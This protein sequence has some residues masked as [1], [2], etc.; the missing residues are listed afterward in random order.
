MARVLG[1]VRVAATQLLHVRFAAQHR[2]NDHLMQ[3]NLLGLQAVEEATAYILKQYGGTRHEIRYAAAHTTVDVVE[4]IAAHVHQFRLAVLGIGTV[5]NR[6]HAV[7]R[8][9]HE[10]HIVLIGERVAEVRHA[11]YA[12]L[13][14][15]AV[16]SE[17]ARRAAKRFGSCSRHA[18]HLLSRDGSRLCSQ[19]CSERVG[20]SQAVGNDCA[21]G[22]TY[23]LFCWRKRQFGMGAAQHGE[24]N[25][26]HA[27]RLRISF[28]RNFHHNGC[29]FRQN[30]GQY[31]TCALVFIVVC[32]VLSCIFIN[33]ASKI[34]D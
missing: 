28:R 15:S 33:F 14:G 13:H 17:E 7:A 6:L 24:Q 34:V 23:R 20:G 22:L 16:G 1:G 27:E 25:N 11:V 29:K 31:K 3:R 26:S 21:V 4:R 12:V 2:R 9:S 32:F 5:N 30:R 8:G 18:R 19:F 10:L